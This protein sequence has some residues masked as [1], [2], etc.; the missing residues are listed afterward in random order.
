MLAYQFSIFSYYFPDTNVLNKKMRV[1][2]PE[3]ERDD[4]FI[5]SRTATVCSNSRIYRLEPFVSGV[6]KRSISEKLEPQGAFAEFAGKGILK[7]DLWNMPEV[8]EY[9][10][11]K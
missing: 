4:D 7:I 5:S 11:S 6:F 10:K 2:I 1:V 9:E 3:L 8:E